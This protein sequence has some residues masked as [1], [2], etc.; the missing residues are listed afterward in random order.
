VL[1]YF[2]VWASPSW[3]EFVDVVGG[4]FYQAGFDYCGTGCCNNPDVTQF[5]A[6]YLSA[7]SGFTPTI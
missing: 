6:H 3:L 7:W 2:G 4:N 1:G 5:D